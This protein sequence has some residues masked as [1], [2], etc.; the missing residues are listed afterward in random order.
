MRN[1]FKVLICFFVLATTF[2]ISEFASSLE[3]TIGISRSRIEM[4]AKNIRVK[5]GTFP[6][7][8]TAAASYNPLFNTIKL[9]KSLQSKVTKRLQTIEELKAES[10]YA[11]QVSLATIFHEFGHAEL[12]TIIEESREYEERKLYEVLK[13]EVA[14][15]FKRNFPKTKSWDAVHELYGYYRTDVIE[16]MFIEAE[17]ILL[18]N[19]INQYQSRCFLGNN[20][21]EVIGEQSREEFSKLK[22]F[23]EIDRDE[24]KKKV[25]VK[26]IF[27][28]GRDLNLSE[29]KEVFKQEWFNAIW[30]HLEKSYKLPGNR[31]EL[32]A[33]ISKWP[34]L[35]FVTKC[36]ED[37]WDKYHSTK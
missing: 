8:S 6:R 32:L 20:L 1:L 33:Y 5:F 17:N 36:R 37:Q 25:K 12:D 34:E 35:S 9:N 7:G 29:A 14:P 15:W 2:A 31:R 18:Q 27:I 3:K 28:R 23:D 26:Y 11:Y 19:G 10:P 4:V 22:I 16:R 13:F 21:K 24:F 30:D